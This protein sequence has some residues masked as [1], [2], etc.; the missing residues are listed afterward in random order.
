[1]T[2]KLGT[3]AL[4]LPFL[5]VAIIVSGSI[6]AQ[7]PVQKPPETKDTLS[8]WD[9]GV[10]TFTG[11]VSLLNFIFV[12]CIFARSRRDRNE[13]RLRAVKSYW[14]QDFVLQPNQSIIH[15][16]FAP[17]VAEEFRKAIEE[18]RAGQATIQQC[19]TI[20]G[21]HIRKFN[22][23]KQELTVAVIDVLQIVDQSLGEKLRVLLH[24]YQDE[25]TEAMEKSTLNCAYESV[26]KVVE[27]NKYTFFSLLYGGHLNS[28]Q[29]APPK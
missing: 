2:K 13:D 1:M 8:S 24:K 14:F 27:R 17:N 21:E 3:K 10:R 9:I 26:G 7:S 12:I 18:A 6:Y 5:L 16:S 28:A 11:L 23:Q 4:L 25:M 20:V 22:D 29:A 15:K 19:S